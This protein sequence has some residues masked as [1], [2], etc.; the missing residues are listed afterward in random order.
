MP[1]GTKLNRSSVDYAPG[2]HNLVVAA[3]CG[4]PKPGHN[5][6][7]GGRKAPGQEVL[8]LLSP[9]N[10]SLEMSTDLHG[11]CPSPSVYLSS[12]RYFLLTIH[13]TQEKTPLRCLVMYTYSSA[14][15]GADAALLHARATFT[16]I[17]TESSVPLG[18]SCYFPR[19]T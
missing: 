11:I 3:E 12:Q 18:E 7:T 5:A 16:P 17:I 19:H 2:N 8:L 15:I 14:D 4:I 10:T 6:P 1:Q 13:D 9:A